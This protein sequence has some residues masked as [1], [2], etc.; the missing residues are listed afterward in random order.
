MVKIDKVPRVHSQDMRAC[1]AERR[2]TKNVPGMGHPV[3][4]SIKHALLSTA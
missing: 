2:R 3:P 1:I 4:S